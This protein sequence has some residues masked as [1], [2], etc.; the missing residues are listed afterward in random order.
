[1]DI[2]HAPRSVFARRE[3]GSFWIPMFVVSLAL[4]LIYIANAGVMDPILNAEMNRSLGT[5]M[6]DPRMT[7]EVVERM[8][9]TGAT[10][11]KISGFVAIPFVILFMALAT[12]LV[13]KIVGAR[14]AWH[15]ALV[16]SAY[17]YLPRILEGVLNG[18]QGLFVDS[19][20]LDGRYRL[21]LGAGRFLDPDTT[22][23]VSVALLGRLDLFT[24]WVTVLLATGLAVTGR[25][26]R[27]RAVIAGVLLWVLGVLPGVIGALRAG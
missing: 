13:G 22:S 16:V 2:F 1:M 23:S 10:L 19:A 9:S 6:D 26:D 5:T 25:I 21:T 20:Q 14:Q 12:W 27:S 3:N 17:S 4:G 15:A 7:P 11:A 8:R 24:L 18:V